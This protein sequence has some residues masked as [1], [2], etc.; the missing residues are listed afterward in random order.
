MN[1]G[2]RSVS[3]LIGMESADEFAMKAS[4]AKVMPHGYE[5]LGSF[6]INGRMLT[7]GVRVVTDSPLHRPGR[8]G[9]GRFLRLPPNPG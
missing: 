8:V 4:L 7:R 6:T 2:L 9:R 1:P 5:V 3:G